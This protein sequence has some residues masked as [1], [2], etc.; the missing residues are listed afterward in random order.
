MTEK[1]L[2]NS[3]LSKADIRVL[4]AIGETIINSMIKNNGSYN[5][6]LY[7][8]I[9]NYKD[10]SKSKII[11]WLSQFDLKLGDAVQNKTSVKKNISEEKKLI[12]QEKETLDKEK[13]ELEKEKQEFEKQKEE[14]EKLKQRIKELE[15]SE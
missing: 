2:D 5:S 8:S 11:R 10:W 3:L 6:K 4:S 13:L 15:N 7:G 14:M 12:Q 9:E 1:K